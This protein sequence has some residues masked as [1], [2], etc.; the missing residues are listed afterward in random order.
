[1]HVSISPAPIEA[2]VPQ[3][4]GAFFMQQNNFGQPH[5][6]RRPMQKGFKTGVLKP[7]KASSAKS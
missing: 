7:L 6:S 3:G 4:T 5:T 1:M 2:P